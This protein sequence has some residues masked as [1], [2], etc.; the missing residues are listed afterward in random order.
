MKAFFNSP[1]I[2]SGMRP[3]AEMPNDVAKIFAGIYPLLAGLARTGL[4]SVTLF[5]SVHRMLYALR[6]QM[7]EENDG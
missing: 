6:L 5:P 7:W 1:K 2:L 4:V 3:A